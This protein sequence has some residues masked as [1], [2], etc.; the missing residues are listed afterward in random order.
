[1]DTSATGALAVC[2]HALPPS[3][4]Q[5]PSLRD[6]VCDQGRPR[7]Q[8]C[9]C[10]DGCDPASDRHGELLR[11]AWRPVRHQLVEHGHSSV[12]AQLG[13]NQ[14]YLQEKLAALEGGE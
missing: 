5:F 8:R 2:R 1:M 7:R 3:S 13:A 10:R 11:A 6:L 4:P 14:M 9:R 12:H